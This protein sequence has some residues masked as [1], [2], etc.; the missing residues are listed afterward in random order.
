MQEASRFKP[1]TVS[2]RFWVAAAAI[3]VNV[4]NCRS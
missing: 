1:S 2:R 3:E 4:L